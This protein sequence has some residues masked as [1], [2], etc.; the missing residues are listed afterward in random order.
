[1]LERNEA[2]YKKSPISG[3]LSQSVDYYVTFSLLSAAKEMGP[4]TE[5]YDEA[6]I[7]SGN[8]KRLFLTERRRMIDGGKGQERIFFSVPAA[9]I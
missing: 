9:D 2:I 7:F 8:P 1:M 5:T 4:I 3:V 6:A